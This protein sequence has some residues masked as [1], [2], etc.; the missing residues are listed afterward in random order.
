MLG[1]IYNYLFGERK[2]EKIQNLDLLILKK[3]I[4]INN[5]N[6]IDNNSYRIN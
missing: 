4:N 1:Y 2:E 3:S 5:M 6:K